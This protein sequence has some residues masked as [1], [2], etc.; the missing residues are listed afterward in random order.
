[1]ENVEVGLKHTEI[2]RWAQ[3]YLESR[4]GAQ[5]CCVTEQ[6]LKLYVWVCGFNKALV[7]F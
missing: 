1:V 6:T 7:I 5:A 3:A 4:G 2:W